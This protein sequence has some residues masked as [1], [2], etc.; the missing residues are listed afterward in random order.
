MMSERLN[1]TGIADH[2][3]GPQGTRWTSTESNGLP[4]RMECPK[5]AS[6]NSESPALSLTDWETSS[7]ILSRLLILKFSGCPKERK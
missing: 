6:G 5:Y 4:V 7:Y 3:Q 2:P 1:E